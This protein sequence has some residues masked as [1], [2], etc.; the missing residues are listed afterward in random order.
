LCVGDRE[1]RRIR[2]YPIHIYTIRAPLSTIRYSTLSIVP[3]IEQIYFDVTCNPGT[4]HL[5]QSNCK[6]THECEW[7]MVPRDAHNVSLG[8]K[9]AIMLRRL[10]QKQANGYLIK[11]SE[12]YD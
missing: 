9:P 8:V 6:T 10:I 2:R 12:D 1:E 7:R 4:S 3:P 11:P 5:A